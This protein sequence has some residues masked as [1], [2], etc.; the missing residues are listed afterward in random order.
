[1]PYKNNDSENSLERLFSFLI[2]MLHM[3]S[4]TC[5]CDDGFWRGLYTMV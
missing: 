4:L 5:E 3:T 1:M 2:F